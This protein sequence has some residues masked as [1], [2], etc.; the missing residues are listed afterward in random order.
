MK[1]LE[2]LM[3][4]VYSN[5]AITTCRH[6]VIL[7][8]SE[9]CFIHITC[10]TSEYFQSLSWFESVQ[11]ETIEYPNKRWD[12]HIVQKV[13]YKRDKEATKRKDSVCVNGPNSLIKRARE[14]LRAFFWEGDTSDS[15]SMSLFYPSQTLSRSNLP[16]LKK[17]PLSLTHTHTHK[18]CEWLLILIFSIL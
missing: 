1:R 15:L 8:G 17:K 13:F 5:C 2:K 18:L 3:L 11:T 16:H 14:N 6:D 7:I 9:E 4:Y 12:K 10:V